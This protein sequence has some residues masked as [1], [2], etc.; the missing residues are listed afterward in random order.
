MKIIVNTVYINTNKNNKV[1]V[2][3]D[4]ISPS[5]V[6]RSNRENSRKKKHG[7]LLGFIIMHPAIAF[8][9]VVS[10]LAIVIALVAFLM[11]SANV[12]MDT[13]LKMYTELNARVQD[14][15]S[16]FNKKKYYIT[17]DEQ[18]ITHITVRLD[19]GFDTEYDEYGNPIEDDG[20]EDSNGP[21]GTGGNGGGSVDITDAAT[22]I[23]TLMRQK[24]YNDKAIAAAL[25]NFV[26]ESGLDPKCTQGNAMDGKSNSE[27]RAWQGG[28][29][30]RAIGFM[31]VDGSRATALLD[32]ADR[33]GV[34]WYDLDFQV[35]FFM[36]DLAGNGCSVSAFNSAATDIEHAVWH[37]TSKYE[38]CGISSSC[39]GYDP[40]SPR[41]H[42]TKYCASQLDY[43]ERQYAN[44]WSTRLR[45]GSDFY[46]SM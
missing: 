1:N 4:N 8:V 31:Q 2:M 25:G 32:A 43:S 41:G 12:Q 7:G 11:Y 6:A 44:G 26:A 37:F 9:I 34:N 13:I 39:P 16:E 46:D 17:V 42:G 23:I 40:P 24:G 27:V 30:G 19:T 36:S 45:A 28:R 33:A 14:S 10:T 15:K 21:G 22:K 18:G 3:S 29:S 35:D 38:R 5:R 20:D